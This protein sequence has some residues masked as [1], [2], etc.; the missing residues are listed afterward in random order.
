MVTGYTVHYHTAETDQ[1]K[2]QKPH[3]LISSSSALYTPAVVDFSGGRTTLKYANHH[4]SQRHSQP[5]C[6]NCTRSW[7]WWFVVPYTN[8]QTNK[9]GIV[10]NDHL[11]LSAG[12]KRR[13]GFGKRGKNS[14]TV[15]RSEE[16][17][18]GEIRGVLSRGS[19]AS[20]DG[21]GS[22]GD[23]GSSCGG[24]GVAS[25]ADRFACFLSVYLSPSLSISYTV[26][27]QQ[28]KLNNNEP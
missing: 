16:V 6:T 13:M 10:W 26:P 8:K 9:T 5:N 17:L 14:F 11:T 12:R 20:S 7:G 28:S 21:E 25:A 1:T 15:H 3:F 22:G 4:L 19:S 27:D 2:S 24:L 18:P 23:G